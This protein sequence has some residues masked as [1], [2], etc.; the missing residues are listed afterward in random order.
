M[1]LDIYY[2]YNYYGC[3]VGDVVSLVVEVYLF[4]VMLCLVLDKVLFGCGLWD[5]FKG[6]L[7]F[8]IEKYL[9]DVKVYFKL[10]DFVSLVFSVF[11]GCLIYMRGW[12]LLL[13][14]YDV[15]GK[16]IYLVVYYMY[17]FGGSDCSEVVIGLM[18]YG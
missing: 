6:V 5:F 18:V 16:I 14:G 8:I 17:G 4:G 2:D 9:V 3:D 12:V 11:W 13:L 1:V 10:I 7:S 15:L